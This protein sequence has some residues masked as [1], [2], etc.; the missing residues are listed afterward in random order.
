MQD[1]IK[2]AACIRYCGSNSHSHSRL[3]AT[4]LMQSTC[5]REYNRR[6]KE[7]VETSWMEGPDADDDAQQP[8]TA[9]ETA[10]SGRS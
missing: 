10:R 2:L 7:V 6:V 5:R 1:P 9:P 3:S 4:S 8:Q